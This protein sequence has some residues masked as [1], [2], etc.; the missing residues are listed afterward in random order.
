MLP[1]ATLLR[2][3]SADGTLPP[4]EKGA[5]KDMVICGEYGRAADAL[6]ARGNRAGARAAEEAGLRQASDTRSRLL[7]Q[8][9]TRAHVPYEKMGKQK[10]NKQPPP[11]AAPHQNT[12]PPRQPAAQLSQHRRETNA[13]R[14]VV[15]EKIHGANF[16]F[17]SDG[18]IV[19][20][21]SRRRVLPPDENFFGCRSTGLVAAHEAPVLGIVRRVRALVPADVVWV[22]GEL[23]G[24]G[25]PGAPTQPGSILVQAGIFYSNRLHFTAFDVAWAQR[26]A[27]RLRH[28]LPFRLAMELCRAEGVLDSRVLFEGTRAECVANFD[29]HFDTTIPPRFG[30]PRLPEGADSNPA[31]GII[32]RPADAEELVRTADAD[33]RGGRGARA[34]VKVKASN[35]QEIAY[36]KKGADRFKVQKKK[37]A[38]GAAA[39]GGGGGGATSASSSSSPSLLEQL[40]AEAARR[41]TD[42]RVDSAVSKTGPIL[43]GR[44]TPERQAA[45]WAEIVALVQE[46]LVEELAA[47]GLERLDQKQYR[48]LW[49]RVE[50]ALHPVIN[51][52]AVR[53]GDMVGKK[54]KKKK[55]KKKGKRRQ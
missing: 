40:W 17:V 4:E 42:S 38:A 11:A 10:R 53:G 43:A 26:S 15:T 29:P 28:Y 19:S 21:C 14:W 12:G 13:G 23:Y 49:L 41:I 46:D 47:K 6:R 18:H 22:F 45:L 50:Q 27:P 8:D 44:D 48:E 31:E 20:A 55:K 36:G 35:F 34:M 1:L 30:L 5:L 9:A 51:R 16:C 33:G 25:F 24:G 2:S 54:K 37:T 3:I 52:R 7:F 39:A 32:A